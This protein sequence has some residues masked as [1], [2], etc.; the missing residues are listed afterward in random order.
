MKCLSI[1]IY[2][3]KDSEITTLEKFETKFCAWLNLPL[4]FEFDATPEIMLDIKK[5]LTT[6]G[7][8]CR[9]GISG[10]CYG[11]RDGSIHSGL[12]VY[13]DVSQ[14][15]ERFID[16]DNDEIVNPICLFEEF[17]ELI[18]N[19][20][21]DVFK[22]ACESLGLSVKSDN[23][24]NYLGQS[25]DDVQTLYDFQ[26]DVIENEDNCDSVFVVV[27]FHCGGDVRGNYTKKYV[28]KFESMDDVYSVIS[29][30]KYLIDD[31]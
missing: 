4:S 8:T 29:P 17:G 12:T 19:L 7:H 13:I 9:D 11:A 26:F 28:Y 14:I 16:E 24:Y 10:G 20:D 15:T 2:S 1:K 30:S 22:E 21:G 27:M 31:E 18:E 3:K 5:Y 25:S 6:D 23:T